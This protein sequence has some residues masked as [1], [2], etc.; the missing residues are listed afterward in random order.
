MNIYRPET[1]VKVDQ[2]VT[3]GTPSSS[4]FLAGDGSYQ[5]ISRLIPSDAT[6]N[7]TASKIPIADGSAH[8]NEWVTDATVTATGSTNARPLSDRFGEVFNVKDYGAIGDGATDATTT[9]T[10][11]DAI[12]AAIEAADLGPNGNYLPRGIVYFPPGTYS[13]YGNHDLLGRF[14]L[15]ITG[16]SCTT[17]IILIND[18]DN[19]IFTVASGG[20][21][22]PAGGTTT[23]LTITDLGFRGA[24]GRQDTA[25]FPIPSTVVSPVR[26]GGWVLRV[27][28]SALQDSTLS[29]LQ[30]EGQY[31]GIWL[32]QFFMVNL[33]N[34]RF[35]AFEGELPGTAWLAA[36]EIPV[37]KYC[38]TSS[39]PSG[40]KCYV[41]V[42]G[43]TTDSSQPT[44]SSTI[45]NSLAVDGAVS[46]MA[47]TSGHAGTGYTTGDVVT[48]NGGNPLARVAITAADGVVTGIALVSGYIGAG[49]EVSDE[50]ITTDF[51][52]IGATAG[53]GL[54]INITALTLPPGVTIDNEVTWITAYKTD[55]VRT[56]FPLGIAISLGAV[57]AGALNYGITISKCEIWGH[58]DT[59][60]WGM[61]VAKYG[62]RM[63]ATTAVRITDCI[64][65]GAVTANIYAH[66]GCEDII[67]S[68]CKFDSAG[69]TNMSLS[70]T[71]NLQ[72]ALCSIGGGGGYGPNG[73]QMLQSL[74]VN[75][76]EGM[77]GKGISIIDCTNAVVANNQSRGNTGSGIV[78]YNYE[79][80]L[81]GNVLNGNCAGGVDDASV[82][83]SG[84]S[85][86]PVVVC[87]NLDIAVSPHAPE[88]ALSFVCEGSVTT[89]TVTGN[90]WG[91]G[92]NLE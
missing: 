50:Y 3:T 7:P 39:P 14:G 76:F 46:T 48:I 26:T 43:G 21:R 11:T 56:G 5:E 77:D 66:S 19:D 52:H 88:G 35:L 10:N 32:E 25:P 2:L 90:Y 63:L 40:D 27:E 81:S 82:Y 6:V 17:S 86:H 16:E 45:F 78:L 18:A 20:S 36:T 51:S 54:K 62:I 9:Q 71:D 41:C 65:G 91:S 58:N 69:G 13:T 80:V 74:N 42:V 22:I 53:S 30:I 70:D 92:D 57:S 83:I 87:G 89:P 4:N 68:N 29:N 72:V 44:F 24:S 47:I 37:G 73:P 49:Y 23:G 60:Q 75:C 55:A 1:K 28:N 33:T 34:I 38:V 85:N 8:I 61:F 67:I 31:N 15:T 64:F 79:G 12:N 59:H 84:T